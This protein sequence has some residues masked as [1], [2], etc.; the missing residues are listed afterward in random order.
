MRICMVTTFYPPYSFGGDATYVRGLSRAL[1]DRGHEVEVVH[2]TD[3]F[4]LLNH[5]SEPEVAESSDGVRVHRL[6]SVMGPLSPLLTQQTGRPMLKAGPLKRLLRDGRFDVVHF[7]NISLVGGPGVLGYSRAP[8]TLYTL[9]EHWLICPTHILWKNK[10]HACDERTCL[11]CSL[12][13]GIPP[14]FWR[15]GSL[16]GRSL[17]HVDQLISPSQFTAE[18]HRAQGIERPIEVLP[19]FS[20]FQPL[21]APVPRQDRRFLYVGRVVTPKGVEPLLT[22]FGANPDLELI[23]VGDGDQSQ[24]LQAAFAQHRNIQFLGQMPQHQLARHYSEATALIFPSL[25]P[26]T[27]GLSIVEAAICGAPSLVRAGSGG[28]P[29]IVQQTGG[30]VVYRD[31]AELVTIMRRMADEP[32]WRDE[33]GALARQGYQQRFTVEL[34]L[35]SYEALI[36]RIAAGAA[37]RLD[38]A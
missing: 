4:R 25:C 28:A 31:E 13:S 29:E 12:R 20:A 3:A 14:Q 24:R 37:G 32:A 16:I 23:V 34:H 33:L 30:G 5:G 9:H 11:S 8:V 26:E 35:D 27:F 18:Q 6:H 21:P 10:S 1:T 2:C 17:E 38:R 15:Y 19:L 36:A 7:H 22:V